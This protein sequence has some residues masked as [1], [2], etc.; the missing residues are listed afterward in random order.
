MF[1]V[2]LGPQQVGKDRALCV[3]KGPQQTKQ[4]TPH[5]AFCIHIYGG[6]GVRSWERV[7]FPYLVITS[8]DSSLCITVL[9]AMYCTLSESLRP[10]CDTTFLQV[11]TRWEQVVVGLSPDTSLQDYL[12]SCLHTFLAHHSCPC[13]HRKI[14]LWPPG[15]G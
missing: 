5:S 6:V 1:T 14:F 9:V 7:L 11:P 8:T 4:W 3:S 12:F 2:N 13:F 10:E 15:G